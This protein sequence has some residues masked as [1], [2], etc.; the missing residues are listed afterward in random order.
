VVY[1]PDKHFFA[2]ILFKE[3]APMQRWLAI[4][5]QTQ[6]IGFAPTMGALHEGHVSLISASKMAGCYTVASI[7]VNPTQFNDP[8]DLEKYPR[9]PEADIKILTEA[10]CDVLFMPSAA[11]VYPLGLD[12]RINLDFA[13]LDNVLEGAFRPGHFQGMATVVS[14]L[15]DIV[16]PSHLFMG[17]K[18]FQQ[19][20]IVARMLQ[21]QNS[22]TQLHVCA[23]QRAPDGLAMSSRN[24]RL[25]APSRALAPN[26]YQALL[27]CKTVLTQTGDTRA[28]EK[29]GLALLAGPAFKIE[30]FEVCDGENLSK[31]DDPETSQRPVALVAT[32]LGGVRLIDNLLLNA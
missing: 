31:L 3:V 10:G 20:A 22:A 27:N 11:E 23:T 26:I 21:L 7:F 16:K 19:S 5:A 4:Q 2:M 15:I 6:A 9:T 1:R 29:A 32:W 18:D 25:D 17:Q 14:R 12:T 28:A 30:Y 24:V 8:K 13:P